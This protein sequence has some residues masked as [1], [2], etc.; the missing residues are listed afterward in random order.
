MIDSMITFI[1]FFYIVSC[2]SKHPCNIPKISLKSNYL[3]D[4]LPEHPTIFI[5]DAKL[6]NLELSKVS[7]RN[8][9]LKY[10]G[11]D[12]VKL[13][14]SNTFSHGLKI[15]ELKEYITTIVDKNT[16]E[17]DLELNCEYLNTCVNNN[18]IQEKHQKLSANESYYMFG[19]NY[20]GI[21]GEL[22]DL[23]EIPPCINC[24]VGG[25][26]TIGI[27]GENSGGRFI[28]IIIIYLLLILLIFHLSFI[29]LSWSWL[30]RINSWFK[31]MVLISTFN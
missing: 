15:M 5:N 12:L 2:N 30:F 29:P 17:N 26:K 1:L 24:D 8:H 23:Y 16:Y 20:D 6:K 19:N 28:Y 7:Q 27:G 10:Y 11:N 9:L 31:K 25:A 22:A 14:S 21:W 18:K 13:S 3:I 4:P